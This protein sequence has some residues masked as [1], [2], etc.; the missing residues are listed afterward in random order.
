MATIPAL[1]IFCLVIGYSAAGSMQNLSNR[2]DE[3]AIKRIITDMTEA[4]NK[5]E[6]NVSLFTRDADFVYADGRW[7]KGATEIERERKARF[8]TALKAAR[9]KLLDIRIRF[10][11]P[12]VALA[13]VTN[14]I[15]GVRGPDGQELP[16]TQ[17]L[18][19][20]VLVRENGKWLLTAF[21]NTT[22]RR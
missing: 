1:V 10:I 13:H 19:L 18:N 20:R 3:E 12:D 5:R 22:I 4:F 14:E 6:A 16:A 9:L 2:A 17:E 15:S 21:H 8:E 7:L 11:K